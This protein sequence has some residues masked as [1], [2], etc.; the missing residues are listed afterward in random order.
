V[1]KTEIGYENVKLPDDVSNDAPYGL[2]NYLASKNTNYGEKNYIK[3][4]ND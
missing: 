4:G 3:C 2:K 1:S